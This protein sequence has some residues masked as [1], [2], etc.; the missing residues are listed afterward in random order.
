V[1]ILQLRS[2]ASASSA[3]GINK[4]NMLLLLAGLMLMLMPDQG[5]TVNRCDAT[6][7]AQGT[8]A[9]TTK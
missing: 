6:G 9:G 3:N 5:A 4:V 7:V 1:R 2:A 8:A